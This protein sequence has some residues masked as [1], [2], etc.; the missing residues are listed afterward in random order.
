MCVLNKLTIQ[1]AI[2]EEFHSWTLDT[3]MENLCHSEDLYKDAYSSLICN[4]QNLD[5]IG[6]CTKNQKLILHLILKDWMFS[7]IIK[8]KA[9]MFYYHYFIW[10]WKL[11][12]LQ[13]GKK[14]NKRHTYGKSRNKIAPI[15]DGITLHR[16]SQ[17][18]HKKYL[19]LIRKFR[20]T[21][22]YKMDIKLS[23]VF[24]FTNNK[25]KN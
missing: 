10:C 25:Y 21:A 11:Y 20:K 15:L 12:L 8:N 23:L 3:K 5:F 19:W 13:E 7:P 16:K 6:K 18:I 17:W 24:L 4:S 14:G 22:R 9:R 1:L 2:I